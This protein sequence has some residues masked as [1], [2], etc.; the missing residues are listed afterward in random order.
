MKKVIAIL[1]ALVSILSFAACGNNADTETTT[2][3]PETT[4]AAPAAQR[5][6]ELTEIGS[7]IIENTSTIEYPLYEPKEMVLSDIEAAKSYIGVDPT[8]KVEKAVFVDPQIG[9]QPFSLCLVKPAEGVD[10]EALKNEILEGV[11]YRKWMCV[12]AEKVLVSNCG[13]T[14]LMVMASEEIVDDVYNA[15]NIVASGNA[16]PALTKAGEV[17]EEPP[18]DGGEDADM[19]AP[20]AMPEDGEGIILG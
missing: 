7:K 5:E 15:F 11:N 8:D 12:A 14:I 19:N 4:T 13:D 1:L 9:V 18:V 20:A 10:V 16:S 17:Q 6:G 2:L 3:A